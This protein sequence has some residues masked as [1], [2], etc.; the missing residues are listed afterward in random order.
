MR[1]LHTSDWHLGQHFMGKTREQE[2]RLFLD[3]LLDTVQRDKVDAVIIA[4]DIF[5]TGVPP[6]YARTLYNQFVVELQA[7]GQCQL[8]VMGGNH[9]S[10]ATLHES[11]GLLACLNTTVIGAASDDVAKQVVELTQRNGEPGAVLCGIPYIRPRDVLVSQSG[12]SGE[13]KQKALLT[14]GI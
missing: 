4:G 3:W 2:H 13:D 5:D 12:D 7:A 10:V 1:I 8:V 6:S 14:E 9:D 11:R